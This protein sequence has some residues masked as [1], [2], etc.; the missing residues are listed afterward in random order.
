MILSLCNCRWQLV[1]S[2]ESEGKKNGKKRAGR[3]DCSSTVPG[4]RAACKFVANN[5]DS[6]SKTAG[7]PNGYLD[8]LGEPR[9][10][11]EPFTQV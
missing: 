3:S 8:R 2:G 7:K 11:P 4:A 10:E 6:N 1:A 9:Q 5:W